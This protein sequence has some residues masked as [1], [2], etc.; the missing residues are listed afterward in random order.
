M[1][2]PLTRQD[3]L[4]I[5]DGA[6]NKIIDRLI[7]RNDVQSAADNARDRILNTIN[8]FHVENQTILRQTNTQSTQMARRLTALE[9]Q[10]ATARQEIRML[11]QAINRLYEIQAQ[12][13]N[14][15]RPSEYSSNE[16]NPSG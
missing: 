11:T 6:K 3:M 12:Q 13:H 5:T 1:S 9:S 16:F 2:S 15:A 4:A 8:A 7:S 10:L 14:R